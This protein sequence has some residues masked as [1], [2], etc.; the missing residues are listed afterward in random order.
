M[1]TVLAVSMKTWGST[2][3]IPEKVTW[4]QLPT[5]ISTVY[6][7][8]LQINELI[9]QF[10]IKHMYI[11]APINFLTEYQIRKYVQL[12]FISSATFLQFFSI[13]YADLAIRRK[14]PS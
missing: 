2:G 4:V 1:Q 14:I 3:M 12:C 10:L 6:S 8:L 5:R 11:F 13:F 7:K 9:F